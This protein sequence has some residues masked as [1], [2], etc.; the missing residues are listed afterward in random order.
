MPIEIDLLPATAAGLG[1]SPLWDHRSN[2]LW[3]ADSVAATL[4]SSDAE[5]RDER[6][7][8]L[9]QPLGSIGLASDGL[10]LSLADGFY[11]FDPETGVTRLI[12]RP[13]MEAKTRL[14]DGKA[15][16]HGRI[17][18][19]SM[20]VGDDGGAG[21]LF[22]LDADGATSRIEHGV[23]VGNALCFSPSGD[24]M[25]F[26]DSMDGML[27]RYAYDPETGA[28]GPRHDLADC[29]EQGSGP[30][31]ATVDAQGRIWVA[32]VLAQAV[33]CYAPDGT[34]IRTIPVPIPYPSCPAFGGEGLDTLYVTSIANSGHKL[35]ADHPDAGRIIT[36]RG[37]DAPGIAEGVYG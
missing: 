23:V 14:N 29:R 31:G 22:R 4:R 33:A 5:G 28:I 13:D 6:H 24:A 26:A 27:R 37:L 35:V 30:D 15:D 12:A 20:R 10:I 2:R 32:L 7:W 36:I 21:S 17:L 8:R 11:R 34:L 16:R 1:E 25:H 19:A 3:W 18:T 9:D